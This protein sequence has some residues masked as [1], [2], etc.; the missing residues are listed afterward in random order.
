MPETMMKIATP[1][2]IERPIIALSLSV[3]RLRDAVKCKV[4]VDGAGVGLNVRIEVE[5]GVAV[6]MG[7]VVAFGRGRR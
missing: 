1:M 3:G 2:P 4:Y 6:R 7:V 5:F